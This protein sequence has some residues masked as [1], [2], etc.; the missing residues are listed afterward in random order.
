MGPWNIPP[1]TRL[2][3]AGAAR[4]ASAAITPRILRTILFRNGAPEAQSAHRAHVAWRQVEREVRLVWKCPGNKRAPQSKESGDDG[5]GVSV[6]VSMHTNPHQ[7]S[8]LLDSC[9]S[10]HMR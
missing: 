4:T 10:N 1:R 7:H 5:F 8:I 3:S 9:G 6:S 2:S